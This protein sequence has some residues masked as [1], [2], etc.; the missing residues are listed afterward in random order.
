MSQTFWE[1]IYAELDK[2][3]VVKYEQLPNGEQVGKR[4]EPE[5]AFSAARNVATAG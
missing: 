2:R 1:K 5:K 3:I 4:P